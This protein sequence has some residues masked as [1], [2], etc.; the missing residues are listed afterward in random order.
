M[1]PIIAARGLVKNYG[2]T[3]ALDNVSFEVEPGPHSRPDRA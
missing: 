3:H 1:S 2:E